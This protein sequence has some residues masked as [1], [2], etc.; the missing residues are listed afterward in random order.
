MVLVGSMFLITSWLCILFRISVCAPPGVNWRLSVWMCSRSFP[1]WC[2]VAM[3]DEL[4]VSAWDPLDLPYPKSV[5]SSTAS[6]FTPLAGCGALRFTWGQSKLLQ[7]VDWFAQCVWGQRTLCSKRGVWQWDHG[8]SVLTGRIF[9][10]QYKPGRPDMRSFQMELWTCARWARLPPLEPLHRW[11]RA[12]GTTTQR[13]LRGIGAANYAGAA[14]LLPWKASGGRS[15]CVGSGRYRI[16]EAKPRVM[17]GQR[18]LGCRYMCGLQRFVHVVN[19]FWSTIPYYPQWLCVRGW[20]SYHL[21]IVVFVYGVLAGW[22]TP[23]YLPV[24]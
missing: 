7:Q 20:Y 18:A 10:A 22:R 17:L 13:S 12:R 5:G 21:H 6:L 4:L 1:F 16:G 23:R 9:P 14:A 2:A 19:P 11:A 3:Y 24:I 15:C 8:L